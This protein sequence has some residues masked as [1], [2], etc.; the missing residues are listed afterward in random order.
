M[1]IGKD[2]EPSYTLSSAFTHG[3]AVYDARGNGDGEIVPTITG[4]HNGRISD[5]TA[6]ALDRAS[7]NQGANA[8]YNIGVDESDTAYSV[9][10][11]GQ[12][13]VCLR[14]KSIVRRLTPKECERLQGYPD[15]YTKFGVD[16]KEI[17]DNARY[18]ALGNSMALPCVNY[19]IEGIADVM[20]EESSA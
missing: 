20:M 13:A 1:G 17:S 12:G 2:G 14:K 19:V 10:A 6:I 16:G 11:N 3:V 5:Y 7:F 15:D 8:Q 4:D 18:K 9:L